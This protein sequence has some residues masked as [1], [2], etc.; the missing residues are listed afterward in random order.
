VATNKHKKISW[1]WWKYISNDNYN[2]N[3]QIGDLKYDG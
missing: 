1:S 2:H 3:S